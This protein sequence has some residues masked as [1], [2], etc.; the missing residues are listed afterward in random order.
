MPAPTLPTTITPLPT[1]PTTS[2]PVTFD[3]RADATLLAQQA[4]VP[5]INA[6]NTKAY[7]NAVIAY[8]SGN[9]ADASAG[10]AATQAGL[11][12]TSKTGADAARDS[13]IAARD[14]ALATYDSFDDRY[15][16]AKAVEPTLDNDGAAL[17]A[18]A[19]YWDTV[20]NGG[21]LRVWQT[22]W[23]TIPANVASAVA[24]TPAGNLIATNVQDSL[25]ELDAEKAKTGAN[26]DITALSGLTTALSLGQG[27]TGA[28]TAPAAR[29]ALGA[30]ATG[31]A[32]FTAAT[33]ALARAALGV[34]EPIGTGQTLQNMSASRVSGVTY[35][36]STGQAICVYISAS[37]S[38]AVKIQ[39]ISD[40]GLSIAQPDVQPGVVVSF[41][42]LVRPG[43]TYS[44]TA[45]GGTNTIADWKE[46][47]A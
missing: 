23:V 40:G 38:A 30:A 4:M 24:T 14:A 19:L 16:G 42:F 46:L 18:G 6:E 9:A 1:P 12:A 32:V 28:T 45:T 35:T 26:S 11:A 2:D 10:T 41:S 34:T 22:A 7:N 25:A 15:L 44:L 21:C 20:L 3:V 43:G 39:I 5:E 37:N 47:R 31:D 8:D 33:A 17:I 13:A 29:T 27:G 36:N